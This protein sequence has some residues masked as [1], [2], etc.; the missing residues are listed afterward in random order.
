MGTGKS[1]VSQL[2]A[3]RLGWT[4][5]D[6]DEEIV[7]RAGKSIP[8]IFASDGE[9]MFRD[10]ESRVLRELLEES[11]RVV[12][13]GGGAVL[14]EEN[15]RSMRA[16]GWVVALAAD[17]PSLLARVAAGGDAAGRPLLAGDAEARIDALLAARRH[18]YDF[19]HATVDTSRLS[20]EE[21]AE[22]LLRWM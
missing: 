20:P 3:K 8:D 10:M 12:A 19:A 21:V 13:T 6:T 1:T 11:G 4:R 14:R 22:L 17:K 15:R 2:L 9:Q 5:I 7:R 16:G 18:A